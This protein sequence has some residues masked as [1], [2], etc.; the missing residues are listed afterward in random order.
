[1]LH[2]KIEVNNHEVGHW[3]AVRQT[4]L[5]H[6]D[7]VHPYKVTLH[8]ESSPSVDVSGNEFFE[9]FEVSALIWHRYSDG[10][11]ALIA[12]IMNLKPSRS[13]LL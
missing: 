8:M 13:D 4:P 5:K 7:G 6:P 11:P 1:M 3:T 12:Q 2:G 9:E 10:A